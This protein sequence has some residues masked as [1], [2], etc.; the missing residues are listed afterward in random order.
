MILTN[1]LHIFIIFTHIWRIFDIFRSG[2]GKAIVFVQFVMI[3]TF[4]EHFDIFGFRINLLSK[5]IVENDIAVNLIPCELLIQVQQMQGRNLTL[6]SSIILLVR[7]SCLCFLGWM[8]HLCKINLKTHV[9]DALMRY[10]LPWTT[11]SGELPYLSCKVYN[12]G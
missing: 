7:Y 1:W 11:V 12:I 10:I 9:N 6:G 2:I 3:K 8:L 4:G 5:I